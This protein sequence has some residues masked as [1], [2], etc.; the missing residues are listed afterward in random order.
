[1]AEQ[2]D[3]TSVG[4][5]V[6]AALATSGSAPPLAMATT[7][8]APMAKTTRSGQSTPDND[9]QTDGQPTKATVAKKAPAKKATTTATP[10]AGDVHAPAGDITAQ[11]QHL[12]ANRP[13][14]GE[15]MDPA[16]RGP[17]SFTLS[18]QL[19]ERLRAAT[20]WGQ[21]AGLPEASSGKVSDLAQDLL[22]AGIEDLERRYNGGRPFPQAP[23][24]MPTGPGARG[25]ASLK[26][27]QEGRRRQKTGGADG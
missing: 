12:M 20:Y 24:K 15:G 9:G 4:P 19:I 11:V 6:P 1:M 27:Y 14:A 21:L 16:E 3:A 22:L 25:V 26:E 18:L 2:L 17:R 10:P 7:E 23:D 13:P 5:I 8:G